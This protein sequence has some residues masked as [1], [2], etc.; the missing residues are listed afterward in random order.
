MLCA[1]SF[2][3]TFFKDPPEAGEPQAQRKEKHKKSTHEQR[4]GFFFIKILHFFEMLY[5][6]AFTAKGACTLSR[7]CECF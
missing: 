7:Q 4:N 1:T 2:R 3:V 5:Y 6:I